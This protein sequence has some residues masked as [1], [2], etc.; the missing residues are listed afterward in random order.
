M[1]NVK[2]AALVA[3]LL[4]SM[5]AGC[6]NNSWNPFRSKT[7]P[8]EPVDVATMDNTALGSDA[9]RPSTIDTSGV[10][11]QPTPIAISSG[12]GA[13]TPAPDTITPPVSAAGTGTYTIQ[14]KD[15]L[16]SI[17]TRLLGNGQRY[18]DIIAANPGLDP[19]K[20]AVGQVIKI[21]PK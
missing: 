7:P 17:A 1:K 21:P 9:V 19:K 4:S 15:T 5:T 3:L 12:G 14:K 8:P 18:R 20:L 13:V 10:G 2:Y 6:K 16:W 11:V